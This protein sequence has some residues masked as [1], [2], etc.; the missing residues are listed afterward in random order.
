MPGV[1]VERPAEARLPVLATSASLFVGGT[2]LCAESGGSAACS[3][4]VEPY[5]EERL[6]SFAAFSPVPGLSDVEQLGIGEG[7]ACARTSS[8]K[9]LCWGQNPTGQLGTGDRQDSEQPRLVE[10]L[11]PA[12]S[13][14]VGAYHACA[15]LEDSTVRCWGHAQPMGWTTPIA[16]RL[17]PENLPGLSDVIELAAAGETTCA[18]K[19]DGS[20][21]CWGKLGGGA[22]TE[23][24]A[25]L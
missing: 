8:G 2:M 19:R 25:R 12:A 20:V 18:R 22:P 14:A 1:E 3:P 4:R 23:V 6:S 10:A 11:P 7:H 24:L 16:H 15:L 5:T 9:V 17:A 21:H 13:L